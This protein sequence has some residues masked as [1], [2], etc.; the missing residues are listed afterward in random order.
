MLTLNS[1]G[2]CL[3]SG[4][5]ANA[6][7]SLLSTSNTLKAILDSGVT[8]VRWQIEWYSIERAVQTTSATA[9]AGAGTQ[10]ITVAAW[11]ANF[12]VAGQTFLIDSAAS[13]AQ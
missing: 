6:A 10:T 2:A 9:V 8:R 13:G 1:Y 3:D 12:A 5:T 11:L 4:G 7:G